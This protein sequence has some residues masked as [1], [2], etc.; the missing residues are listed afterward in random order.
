MKFVIVLFALA[1]V[2]LAKPADVE[3][4]DNLSFITVVYLI[5]SEISPKLDQSILIL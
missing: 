5:E 1:A 2:C 4:G 3:T